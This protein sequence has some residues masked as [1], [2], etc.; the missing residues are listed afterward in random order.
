MEISEALDLAAAIAG[1]GAVAS[2]MAGALREVAG[3]KSEEEVATAMAKGFIPIDLTPRSRSATAIEERLRQLI[4]EPRL[5]RT[6]AWH[7]G[8]RPSELEA[9]DLLAW[10]CSDVAD[11]ILWAD[12]YNKEIY[13]GN[14]LASAFK[15]HLID[16]PALDAGDGAL[17]REKLDSADESDVLRWIKG[18]WRLEPSYDV[19]GVAQG[20]DACRVTLLLSGER[21]DGL[22]N[23]Q[24]VASEACAFLGGGAPRQP[25]ECLGGD[26]AFRVPAHLEDNALSWLCRTQGTTLDD[27]VNGVDASEFAASLRSEIDAASPAVEFCPALEVLATCSYRDALALAASAHGLED[28]AES[29][30][31]GA[32]SLKVPADACA[33]VGIVC[34]VCGK[35]G[36]LGIRLERPLPVDASHIARVL[37]GPGDRFQSM[38]S[39]LYTPQWIFSLPNSSWDTPLAA[40]PDPRETIELGASHLKRMAAEPAHRARRGIGR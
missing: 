31:R 29:G 23:T 33:R 30:F 17:A 35:G 14:R 37:P 2:A 12:S 8:V 9:D 13:D 22:S 40:A 6:A 19:G 11:G 20:M 39:G 7:L 27:V 18:R 32:P 38:V 5:A 21:E 25:S 3:W 10:A 36:A 24:H 1:G 34:N 4:G 16:S 28:N 26:G 15:R